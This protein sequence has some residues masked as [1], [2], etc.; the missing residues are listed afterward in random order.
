LV[1]D[2]ASDDWKRADRASSELATLG[3]RITGGL[4]ALRP[5]QAKPVQERI[6]AILAKFEHKSDAPTTAPA[7]PTPP[8]F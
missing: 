5:Q 7:P 6:D 4:R 3:P 2:L 8:G 1:S